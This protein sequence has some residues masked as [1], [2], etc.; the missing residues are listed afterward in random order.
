MAWWNF[1]YIWCKLPQVLSENLSQGSNISLS[2]KDFQIAQLSIAEKSSP[3]WGQVI[4]RYIENTIQSG[5]TGYFF[6]RNQRFRQNRL[7]ANGRDNMSKFMDLLEMNGKENYVNIQWDSPK[8]Y[9]R[10]ISGLVGRWMQRNEK[11]QVT[12]I[13]PLSVYQ[14]KKEYEKLEY[15]MYN[16]QELRDL[17]NESGMQIMPKDV[18]IPNDKQ[19]LEFWAAQMQRIPEE[20]KYQIGI[21]DVMAANGWNSTLKE[22][23]L[24]DSTVV[25][26]IGTYTWMDNEGVIHVERVSPENAIYSYTEYD[27]FRDT[28]WRGRIISRKISEIRKMW[29]KEFNPTNPL[30]LDEEAIFKIAATAK[31][32]QLQDKLTWNVNYNLAYMRPYDEWNVDMVEFEYKSVDT[33]NLTITTTKKHKAT[34]IRKG[35][36]DKIDENDQVIQDTKWNIYRGV[37][38]R[39]GVQVLEWG[40]KKNMIRPQ[41][42]K[43]IGNAEFSFS[44]YMY[45][46]FEMRNIAVPEKI[47]EPA[48][49][50]I[51]T[52]LKMQQLIAKMKPAGAAVNVDAL[53]ELDL[54]LAE[55]NLADPLQVQ[56]I[57]E[58]T[59]MLY[60][61]GRD[62][63]GNPI[64]V[65]ITELQNAGFISQ[66]QALIQLYQFNYQ[67]LK[68]ELG[69]DPNI[70]SQALTPRVAAGNVDVAQA[71][72]AAATDYMYDAF[73]RLMEDTAVKVACLLKN[74]VEY[75]ATVY[76][77]MLKQDDVSGRIFGTKVQ[78]LPT[79]QDILN[80]EASMNQYIAANPDLI[81]F[82]DPFR[83]RRIAREDTKLAEELFRQGQKRMLLDRRNQAKE[84]SEMNAKAQQESLAM[85]GQI[86]K[87]LMQTEILIKSELEKNIS[88]NQQKQTILAG[89]IDIYAKGLQMPPELSQLAQQVI[90]NLAL[91]LAA[92]N[93][94]AEAQLQQTANEEIAAS[95]EQQGM[96][97]EELMAQMQQQQGQPMGEDEPME[98]PM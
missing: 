28:T 91:P 63:E 71:S 10:I 8:I 55:G 57:Y 42:P 52:R 97:P 72:A 84:N 65:P 47:E 35:K 27:D 56:K 90:T 29:G 87:D 12:A 89:I 58:Q 94:Q 64:P 7:L 24:T 69:E 37:Y 17:E 66:M 31:E 20:I 39:Q 50:M 88:A 70:I 61:R 59:G 92:E 11:V 54:G 43:E 46:P 44:F 73:K 62:A 36:K 82:I 76:R 83:L 30:A 48:N 49:N 93:A 40:I 78:M 33:E 5:Y 9:N 96:L 19:E 13:D 81:L 26:L 14:K 51:L 80:F 2:A 95:A 15:L 98:S 25:G 85:K 74:S 45:Q 22:K 67:V 68:D 18:E 3:K 23:S 16:Q 4:S 75:G 21:N 41:D 38:V 1:F 77:A 32:Y 79:D 6:A 53:N 34:I 86:D 60:Y